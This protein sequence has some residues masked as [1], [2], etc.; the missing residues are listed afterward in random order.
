MNETPQGIFPK[1]LRQSWHEPR[2]FF[3]WLSLFSLFVLIVT[4]LATGTAGNVPPLLPWIA[5]AAILGFLLGVPAFV[6]SWIP[7]LR[8][9]FAW[10]LR[11]KLLDLASI[12][13]LVALFY[14]VENWRGRSAWNDFRR[15]QEALG[16]RFDLEGIVRPAVPAAENMFEAEPWT[17]FHF[18]KTDVGV[19]YQNTNLQNEVWFDCSGPNSTAAPMPTDVFAARRINLAEWQQ[20][21]R[22][23][24]N[25]F[26]GG[27]SVTN[28]FPVPATP[29]TPAQTVLFAL[30]KFEP[31]LTQIRLAAQRPHARFWINFEDG[32]GALL[33][34]LAKMKG[35]AQYTRLRAIALLAE[36]QTD[37]ALHD[38][39]LA[40]RIN[41]ALQDE[42]TL[43]S[44][45]VRI[46]I[47]HINLSVIWE[48]LADHRW[49]EAQLATLE[50]ELA[51]MDFLADYHT[52]MKGERY[53][54]TWAMDYL[55]RTGDLDIF[56]EPSD[57][58][59]HG[60]FG[61]QMEQAV[62]RLLFGLAPTGWFDQNKL[63]LAQKHATLIRPLVDQEKQ[64]VSPAE[65]RR[66]AT[67]LQTMRPTPYDLFSAALIP[68]INKSA[69][70][71]ADAQT[72]ANLARI[73]VALER[74][75]L[76]SGGY[77]ESLAA[78]VPKFIAQLPH[79]IINSQ[80]LKYRH[81]ADGSFILY[82]VGWNETDD[83]GTVVMNKSGQ[84]VEHTKGDWAWRYPV[85]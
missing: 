53:L 15:E 18:T 10:L 20:F 65:S 24:N 14:A 9:F 25:V 67:A 82:S 47:A 49:S 8:P 55:R 84:S 41:G 46:A 21:Y 37:A 2:R 69:Q 44:Q 72:Y 45:L 33:P 19:V 38:L 1:R 76:A 32:A 29:Q 60:D 66:T 79:D 39:H 51:Q 71:F 56:N 4:V 64:I 17:D 26:P 40:M 57:A 13:T 11:H 23:T 31:R 48:G 28:Y 83:G 27:D 80:P 78:L 43:I 85:R 61:G 12:A 70:K 34:H 81:T 6:L 74:H 77:P 54:G 59:N 75:R 50:H 68:A 62:G 5:L 30:R 7:P 73:A 35:I 58:A 42:P 16:I 3:F 52:G 63:S 22:S 36:G